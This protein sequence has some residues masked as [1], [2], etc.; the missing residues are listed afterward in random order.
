MAFPTHLLSST[1]FPMIKCPGPNSSQTVVRLPEELE[2]LRNRSL[3]L[4]GQFQ[5][6]TL[7]GSYPNLVASVRGEAHQALCRSGRHFLKDSLKPQTTPLV[8]TVSC[9]CGIFPSTYFLNVIRDIRRDN[10]IIELETLLRPKTP[11]GRLSP[12]SLAQPRS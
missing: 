9:F 4:Q 7:D 12:T 8:R 2:R 6:G 1:S 10:L 3:L 11:D 5:E